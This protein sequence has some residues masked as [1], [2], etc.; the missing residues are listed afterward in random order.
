M[1]SG[2]SQDLTKTYAYGRAAT[3]DVDT[4]ILM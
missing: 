1:L 4:Q 3:W 2:I